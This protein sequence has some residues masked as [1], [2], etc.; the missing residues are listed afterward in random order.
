MKKITLL[1][2]FVLFTLQNNAQIAAGSV[3]PDFTVQ[4]INGVTHS[5]SAYLAAGKTVIMDVSATW[6]NPCWNYHKTKA[7]EDL[8]MSYGPGGSNEVVVLFVEG[9]N[10]TTLADLNGTGTNTRGN[11]VQNTPYP[12]LDSRAI[13]QLY[14]I[15]YFP[16]LF[17]ICPNGLVSEIPTG[18][19]TSIRTNI[20]G[21][22]GAT[23]VGVQNHVEAFDSENALC[24][25]TGVVSAKFRNFGANTVTS[26]TLKLKENGVV[27]ETKA[28]T[29]TVARYTTRTVPFTSQTLNPASNYTVEV[30][31]VNNNTLFNP[32]LA[33]AEMGVRIAQDITETN[34]VVKIYTDNY[35]GEMSWNIKNSAGTTVASGGPYAG[36]GTAA[37][38]ADANT[39]KIINATLA[40]NECYSVNLLDSFGDG[41][42]EGTT[43]HGLEIFDANNTSL[44]NLPAGN[45]GTTLAKTNA[46]KTSSP[47]NTVSNSVQKINLTP[48]PSNGIFNL[49]TLEPVL[50]TVF[51]VLGKS[52]YTSNNQTSTTINLTGLNKG[53]YLAKIIGENIN[54]TE[55]LILN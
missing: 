40:V 11:W 26:A 54:T 17:R 9:D 32:A 13:A 5:L 31:N 7:L 16:T 34:V 20:N 15:T 49:N 41:W 21:N 55:K 53:I 36:N 25:A 3:A 42:A 18:T 12:I 19:A 23:L 44:Y 22:C 29:G 47:L 43:P 14:E 38:G 24:S 35:P 4:D 2:A 27:V 1:I 48:N 28:Y 33:N 52:V 50:V 39:T 46:L 37:G 10:A 51:D 8:Y 30:S 6:C 45:F